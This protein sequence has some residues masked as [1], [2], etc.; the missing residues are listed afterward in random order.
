M[1]LPNLPGNSFNDKL[2]QENFHK[3]HI[4]DIANDQQVMSGAHRPGIGGAPLPGQVIPPAFSEYP[5][6]EGSKV[7]SWIAYDRQVLYFK[8]YFQEGV[9]ES[10]QETYRVRNCKIYF[11]LED[12]SIQ[13]IEPVMKNSGMP[14]GTIVRRHRVPKPAPLDDQY[15]TVYD[16]NVGKDIIIYGKT[17]KLCDADDFTKNFLFK[18]GIKIGDPSSIPMNPYTKLRDDDAKSRQPLRP[19]ERLDCLRQFL[20]YDRQ[21]LRFKAY[22]DDTESLFG[23]KRELTVHYY[24]A[25]DTME[26]LEVLPR[27]AGRDRVPAFLA[28]GRLPKNAPL[29]LAKHGER[30]ARTLLNTFGLGVTARWLLDSVKSGAK[31]DDFYCDAD[32]V[33]GAVI[34]VY[35]RA[36]QLCDCDEFTKDFYRSKF[37]VEKFEP[38]TFKD[39]PPKRF[40]RK[41]PPYAGWGSAEDS[42]SSCL[43]LIPKPPSRDFIKFLEKDRNGLDSNVFRYLAYIDSDSPIDSTRKIII[44]YYLS[45]DTMSF[46]EPPSRN[47][48]IIPGDFMERRRHKKPED[49]DNMDCTAEYYT[50]RDLHLGA[51]C[52]FNKFNFIITDMDEYAIRYMENHADEFPHSNMGIIMPKIKK[53]LADKQQDLKKIFGQADAQDNGVAPYNLLR[54]ELQQLGVLS[55]HEILTVGRYFNCGTPAGVDIKLVVAVAQEKLKKGAFEDFD[56]LLESCQI[57]DEKGSKVLPIYEFQAIWRSY[58]LPVPVD[59]VKILEDNFTDDGLIKYEDYIHEINY[60]TNPVMMVQYQQAP[61]NFDKR[62][63]QGQ[64]DNITTT[65]GVEE[66]NYQAFM[67]D[68]FGE[69]TA[70]Q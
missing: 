66:I 36:V 51:R 28:R 38:I 40:P 67:K 7:P 59:V 57:R 21:V 39:P 64:M 2:G 8:G 41:I 26:I 42:L 18:L 15:Y 14:Q 55:E 3:S 20:D 16:F 56:R 70:D 24:L 52:V 23:D 43:G 4:F 25:D 13:I 54:A 11:Y 44:S 47:S 22:W 19:Y 30:T 34:N 60:R 46:Y 31:Y 37:G 29:P 45:D 9:T 65:S 5:D 48:G 6:G 49:W 33:L 69:P 63:G 32:L 68:V 58:K 27:N 12:D 10:R 62:Q 61:F 1:A 50:A 53:A 17:F 35:G